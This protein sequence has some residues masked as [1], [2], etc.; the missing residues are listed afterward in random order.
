MISYIKGRIALEDT[1]ATGWFYIATSIFIFLPLAW[2]SKENGALLLIFLFILE[3]VFFQFRIMNK[4]HRLALYLFHTFFILLPVLLTLVYIIQHADMFQAGYGNRH[5]SMA[6]RL[7]TE[8]RVLWLY[9]QMILLPAPSLFG[10][11]QDDIAVSTSFTEPITTIF[12]I[13]GL[14]G[15]LVIALTVIKRAPILA[16]GLLFFLAGHL[17]ESTFIP[18]ELAYEHRNYLP[19]IGLLLLLFYYLGYGVAPEKYMKARFSVMAILILLFAFQTHLRAR[20][21][22][23]NARLYLTEVQHHPKSPRANYEAGKVFGQRLEQGTGDPE[24]NYRA[25]LDYFNRVTS[26]RKNTTSGLFGN[27][28]A[29]I[30]SKQE[31]Q[32]KWINE[33][34]YR[35]GSKPLEQVNLLWLDK[36]TDCIGQGVCREEDLQISRLLLAAISN[37]HANNVNIAV[38]FAIQAKYMYQVEGDI[39]KTLEMAR[40]A[41]SLMP[42]NLY[43][44]L[45]LARYLIWAGKQNRA[46]NALGVAT[47]IDIYNQHATEISELM[48]NIENKNPDK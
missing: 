36:L 5:F 3:L 13:T 34:E 47:K 33:L 22:S 7:L 15:L 23:D 48:K 30:D 20:T 35:L 32:A 38:L 31:I 26:L 21:W 37:P 44:R 24:I 29:S 4:Y 27:I 12:A 14:A 2:F 19:S 39:D 17:M 40:K 42:S 41:V 9:I 43:Y 46:K 11:F 16:F 8:P 28:L 1:P 10:L 18:L 25:A 6:E 45:N